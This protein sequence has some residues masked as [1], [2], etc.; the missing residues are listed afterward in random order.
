M[1]EDKNLLVYIFTSFWNYIKKK[2]QPATTLKYGFVWVIPGLISN[3]FK[4]KLLTNAVTLKLCMFPLLE[5]R[6][7]VKCQWSC[8][9]YW[10]ESGH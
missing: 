1:E 3:N 5:R 7:K 4:L 2:K 10:V 8:S 9:T 6:I